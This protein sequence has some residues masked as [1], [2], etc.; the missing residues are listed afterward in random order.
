M[1]EISPQQAKLVWDRADRLYSGDE[2][3]AA[4]DRMAEAINER[5]AGR[6]PL[7]LVLVQGGVIPAGQ[8]L[9]RLRFPL[10]QDYVHA[11]RYREKTSGGELRWLRDPSGEVRGETILL[12]DDILDEGYTLERV[13]A[14]CLERGAAE[15]LSAVLVQKMHDRGCGFRADFVGLQI[16]DR[17]A[18]GYGMDYKGYLRNADGIYAISDE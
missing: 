11:T 5:L 17:Y 13:A 3:Q 4:F 14:H 10:R 1:S 18:F 7:A 12:I 8:L 15:V 6:D 2:V 16:E 9:P